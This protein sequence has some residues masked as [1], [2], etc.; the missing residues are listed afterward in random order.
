M[1][2]YRYYSIYCDE[3]PS[4]YLEEFDMIKETPCGW[5]IQPAGDIWRGGDYKRWVS[6]TARKRYAYPTKK[7]ALTSFKAKKVRQISILRAHLCG[8]EHE[9]DIANDIVIEKEKQ[10]MKP[11]K[12][13]KNILRHQFSGSISCKYPSK[14]AAYLQYLFL[15]GVEGKAGSL[16]NL[17]FVGAYT[18]MSSTVGCG[19]DG[20]YCEFD[21]FS[22]AEKEKQK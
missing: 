11:P 20:L 12:F 15:D 22:H 7:E 17:G 16:T 10:K 1:I 18:V 9:L 3:G 6:K 4:V 21:L 14:E 13:E 5:W 8:A 2:L 19:W